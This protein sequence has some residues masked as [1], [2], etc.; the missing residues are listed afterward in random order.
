[1]KNAANEVETEDKQVL[2]KVKGHSRWSL[3]L[4]MVIGLYEQG[5]QL[6]SNDILHRSGGSRF[7]CGW[8]PKDAQSFKFGPMGRILQ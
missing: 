8:G 4:V 6:E 7:G 2:T 1:M 3:S 5:G